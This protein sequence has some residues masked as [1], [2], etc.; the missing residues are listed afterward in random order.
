MLHDVVEDSPEWT[1]DRLRKEGFSEDV[2]EAIDSVTRRSEERS[3]ADAS[4]QDEEEKY[5][6]YVRRAARNPIG[7]SVK[8]ADLRDNCDPR[9]MKPARISPPTFKLF[10]TPVDPESE[11]NP[12]LIWHV[13]RLGPDGEY[14][15]VQPLYD[16]KEEAE[17][18]IAELVAEAESLP[19]IA[20]QKA[21]AETK[22]RNLRKKYKRA[23]K[24]LEEN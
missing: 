22:Q 18:R 9:R 19:R 23:I 13:Y 8:L 6:E 1:C 21:E 2:V 15:H 11:W 17:A 5:L 12:G 20:E 4:P 16:T 3:G 10:S 14:H 7:L 24:I